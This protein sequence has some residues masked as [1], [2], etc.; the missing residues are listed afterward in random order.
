MG[1]AEFASAVPTSATSPASA[2]VLSMATM[3]SALAHQRPGPMLRDSL[4][5]GRTLLRCQDRVDLQHR[6]GL[7]LGVTHARLAER[8]LI[9]GVT[10]ERLCHGVSADLR[11]GR[12]RVLLGEDLSELSLLG[13]TAV[14]GFTEVRQAALLVLVPLRPGV[15]T[16]SIATTSKNL[17]G[18]DLLRK[19]GPL[20]CGQDRV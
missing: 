8:L 3:T 12:R 18:R 15:L 10:L 6:R 4:G 20:L 1:S 2:T 14:E 13:V 9:E 5:Q 16:M 19:R 17:T 11:I 7:R